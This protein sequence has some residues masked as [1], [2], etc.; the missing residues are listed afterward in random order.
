[1]RTRYLRLLGVALAAALATALVLA[2]TVGAGP[3]GGKG[4]VLKAKL[5]GAS[6]APDPGD[7]DGRGRARIQLLKRYDAVCFRLRWR[8][9]AAPTAAHIHKGEPGEA[10]P[11]VVPLFD[12]DSVRERGCVD[13]VDRGLLRDIRRNTNDY[14]V[15]I[16]NADF[17]AGAI[18]GQ[19]RKG[20][21]K[22]KN[23]G[24]GQGG[25]SGGGGGY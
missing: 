15:N 14:Y 25:G 17:P 5:D 2:M 23:G 12:A 8:D 16:H 1:M 9:I 20:R 3:G 11:V 19:L 7:P 21:G 24:G 13:Q 4:K 22:G 6:E 18:R 10:G